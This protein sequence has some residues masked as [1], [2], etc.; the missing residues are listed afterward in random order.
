MM[1]PSSEIDPH[2]GT[3]LN[4]RYRI[5]ERLGEG[6]M[7]VVYRGERVKLSRPV[8]IKFLHSPYSGSKEFLIRF[9]REARAMSMLSH[10]CCVSVIDFGIDGAPYIVMDF[11]D[12]YT[13]RLAI[14]SGQMSLGRAISVTRQILSGLAHAHGQGIIHR[15]IKPANIML[16]EATGI[17]DHVR[18]FDFG[19]AKLQDPSAHGDPSV[20]H[21]VGTPA[22][23]APEQ[24]RGDKLDHRVDLYS[25]GVVLFELLTGQ[26]PFD[27]KDTAQLLRQQR[28]VL[29]PRVRE[30]EPE[31]SPELDAVVAK[32]LE[33]EPEKRFANAEDF[34][35]ALDATPEGA[36]GGTS[37]FRKSRAPIAY[38]PTESFVSER[39]EPGKAAV[40]D[41]KS[42]SEQKLPVRKSNPWLW[43][44]LSLCGL[45]GGLVYLS[46]RAEA[47][48]RAADKHLAGAQGRPSSEDQA[49]PLPNDPG[50]E[51]PGAMLADASPSA[52]PASLVDAS[53][54]PAGDAIGTAMHF[55][56]KDGGVVDDLSPAT[57]AAAD[58]ALNDTHESEAPIAP[59]RDSAGGIPTAHT[60]AAVNGL[61]ARG[62]DDQAIAALQYMRSRDARNPALPSLLG[63]LY[64]EKGWFSDGLA[65][66]RE[67]IRLRP[68]IADRPLVQRNAIRALGSDK[69]YPR[70]RAL[71]ARDI[72]R[73]ARN[74]LRH[75]AR[76]DNS[77]VVRKR[78]GA[79]LRQ[80]ER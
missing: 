48:T 77:A 60:L 16:G 31:I 67:A 4:G 62:Q 55:K 15:D 18:I 17:G 46:R 74:Q 20:G 8:A 44:V 64:F 22:Y 49:R 29:P 33:K 25:T 10:P 54:R 76:H 1:E 37:D 78:A 27:G 56:L 32:A 43:I 7:G 66:Y 42:K 58:Q 26:K 75:A 47:P 30:L 57:L 34:L 14:D 65:K 41:A 45:A 2:L 24:T 59:T 50:N 21:L 51:G 9:E 80:L 23:M 5:T 36:R 70:A 39:L 72:G 40:P 12:G 38:A 71:L 63:D 13:L 35:T 19:L 79:V 68:A 61:V 28:D 3:V 53:A 6:G 52:Q 69:S 11:V 73:R